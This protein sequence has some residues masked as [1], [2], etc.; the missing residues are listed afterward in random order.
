MAEQALEVQQV[1]V[2]LGGRR[3]LEDVSFAVA[4]GTFVGLIGP[5]GAG[6]TTLLR[7]VLGL[8]EPTAG[9]VRIGGRAVSGRRQSVGY[10]PQKIRLDPDVPVRGRDLVG[11]GLDGGRWGV[12]FP[13]RMRTQ[14]IEAMLDSVGALEFADVPVGRLSGGQ[15]QRLLIAHALI[16]EP[17]LLL[18][19][20]P[21]SNLDI[22]SAHEVV[23]LVGDLTQKH[24]ISAMLVA[25]DMNPLLG[26]MDQ[27]V[28][29]ANGH[30]LMGSVDE[31]IQ[32]QV[33]SDLYGYEV[34]VIRAQGRVLVVSGNDQPHHT[35]TDGDVDDENEGEVG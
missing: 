22:K 27:V 2:E 16:S 21:L 28:Y 23:R 5:N 6:K 19:D 18:L 17:K 11:L 3:I 24:G 10:V 20:E 26:V 31:V 1:T 8:V 34:E 13:S 32:S 15:Q 35:H 30:A 9:H 12:P 25:H 33:L 7:V 4:P 14:R 29:L